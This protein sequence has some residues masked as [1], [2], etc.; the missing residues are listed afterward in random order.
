[1]SGN[2]RVSQA[3]LWTK[4]FFILIFTA[5][6]LYCAMQ[7]LTPTLPLYALSIG[8]NAAIGGL[9]M[10]VFTFGALLPR[11]FFGIMAD[12]R[13]RKPV[14]LIG[15]VSFT[16][17]VILYHWAVTVPL[18]LLIRFGQG[19]AFSAFST[20]GGTLATD[21]VPASRRS[22]G[23]SYYALS[24]VAGMAIGP[25]V[26]LFLLDKAGSSA[27]F[28][29][30]SGLAIMCLV[31][32]FSMNQEN[33]MS[34]A[35]SRSG[36]LQ[37]IEKSVL[38]PCLVVFFLVFPFGAVMTFIPGYAV[39]RKVDDIGWFFS[40]Y[41]T[42]ILVIRLFA[43]KFSDRYGITVILVP[44][45]LLMSSGLF[46]LGFAGNLSVF[47]VCALLYGLG[48]GLVQPLMQTVCMM[49]SP[50]HRRG[51]ATATLYATMDIGIGLGGTIMGLAVSLT[52]FAS[53]F[54]I[55]A[56]IVTLGLVAY[57]VLLRG[58]IKRHLQG[59]GT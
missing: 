34:P 7:M 58:R 24:G 30:A 47:L 27:L 57:V 55:S 45:I 59:I 4:D 9:L 56:G 28:T 8:G 10:G 48:Y 33:K 43:G 49:L 42:A 18:L 44:G 46:L 19:V 50:P 2:R 51:V 36:R 6:F 32:A 16:F 1:M 12:R 3:P 15:C 38:L 40:V 37:L 53:V 52:G 5:V 21:L 13:G 17:F 22:E 11:P 41:A 54:M 20:A 39:F 23:L 31:M 14:L 26:G 25:G 35:I 29:V